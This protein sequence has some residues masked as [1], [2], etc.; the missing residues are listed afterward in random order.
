[1]E[2]HQPGGALGYREN[3]AMH[4][5][6]GWGDNSSTAAHNFLWETSLQVDEH[7]FYPDYIDLAPDY[8]GDLVLNFLLFHR[9]NISAEKE[10][11]PLIHNQ[12]FSLAAPGAS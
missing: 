10:R 11:E 6:L 9:K 7:L 5:E 4:L 1:M 2:I 12:T 8:W 3:S